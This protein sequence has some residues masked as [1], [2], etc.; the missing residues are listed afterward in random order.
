MLLWLDIC[1]HLADFFVVINERGLVVLMLTQ[2]RGRRN[3]KRCR[4][5]NNDDEIQ[6]MTKFLNAI[7]EVKRTVSFVFKSNTSLIENEF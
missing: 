7:L 1:R 5:T 3:K 4:I 2:E 6:W